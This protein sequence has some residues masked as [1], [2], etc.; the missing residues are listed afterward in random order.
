MC[1]LLY[2]K[3]QLFITSIFLGF[4][5]C[6]VRAIYNTNKAKKTYEKIA[7]IGKVY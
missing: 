7:Y 2:L 6:S 1:F 4:V 3:Y 5:I